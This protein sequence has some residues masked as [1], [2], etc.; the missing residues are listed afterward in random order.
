MRNL[1]LIF[2]VALLLGLV[3]QPAHSALILDDWT[4]DLS[5]TGEGALA[6]TFENIYELGYTGLAHSHGSTAVG[7][8]QAVDGLLQVTAIKDTVSGG[9]NLG[10]D[11][12]GTSTNV[13][14][15]DFELTARFSITN[16]VTSIDVNGPGDVDINFTHL[17]GSNV[18]ETKT[19]D[20]KL[21]IWVDSTR[22]SNSSFSAGGG[23]GFMDGTLIATF[24]VLSGLGG[25]YNTAT[26]LGRDRAMFQLLSAPTG[27][28]FDKAGNDLG[29]Y[30]AGGNIVTIS[31]T[32]SNFD[33]NPSDPFGLPAPGSWPG[34]IADGFHFTD[35][36][37]ATGFFG[38]EDGSFQIGVVPE[39]GSVIIWSLLMAIA[40]GVGIRRKK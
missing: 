40:V 33:G 29:L 5:G 23:G 19:Q 17:A 11:T 21:E 9:S 36:G 31:L 6:G 4:L 13:Y 32:D 37:A 16:I 35:T 24:E 7:G 10:T 38:T 2:V 18:V 8:L 12:G 30:V 28:W 27:V 34:P 39:P 26:S 1:I 25:D 20:G 22:D 15:T 14:N 3:A